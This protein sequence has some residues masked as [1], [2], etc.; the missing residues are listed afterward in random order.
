M[1]AGGSLQWLP[2][3]VMPDLQFSDGIAYPA[4]RPLPKLP[5]PLR[6]RHV[7]YLLVPEF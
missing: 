3:R 4:V 2:A 1:V 7:P 5:L 6:A